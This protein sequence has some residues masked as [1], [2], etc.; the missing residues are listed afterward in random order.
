MEAV[1]F[2]K[3][4]AEAA[5]FGVGILYIG[6]VA[7]E[8]GSSAGGLALDSLCIVV[9]EELLQ[10]QEA[11]VQRRLAVVAVERAGKRRTAHIEEGPDGHCSLLDR[12]LNLNTFE[13]NEETQKEKCS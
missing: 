7:V 12:R 4:V 5:G 9:A 10:S 2:G 13:V 1:R 6:A 3:L 8:L 11:E